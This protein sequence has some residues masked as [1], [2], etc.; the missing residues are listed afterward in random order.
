MSTAI[1]RLARRRLS[2]PVLRWLRRPAVEPPV[3]AV[4]LGDLR[5]LR[6]ISSDF[7][8]DRGL[9]IDRYYIE[10]FLGQQAACGDIAGRVLEIEDDLY[11]HRFGDSARVES[12]DILDFDRSNPRATVYA[13]LSGRE[14]VPTDSFDCIICTQTLHL[15]YDVRAAVHN[16]HA[17]L[18]PGGVLLATV[19]GISMG[20]ARGSYGDYWRFTS[21][22][23]RRMLAEFFGA[24]DVDAKAF[25]NVL[26]AAGFMYGLAAEELQRAELDFHDERYEVLIGLR[27]IRPGGSEGRASRR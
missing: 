6:P 20:C 21:A 2:R 18:R 4:R 13:D 3:G 14:E 5:R 27:A 10:R 22:S 11:T 25:G 17:A 23:G 19:P 15:I 12:V 9:P 16:L 26:A 1:T 24:A 7:G 8:F